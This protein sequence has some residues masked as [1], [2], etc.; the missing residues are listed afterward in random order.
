MYNAFRK[1]TTTNSPVHGM[2]VVFLVLIFF[3]LYVTC[4]PILLW[5][6]SIQMRARTQSNLFICAHTLHSFLHG[7]GTFAVQFKLICM[8]AGA[9]FLHSC[10]WIVAP[11]NIASYCCWSLNLSNFVTVVTGR[12]WWPKIATRQSPGLFSHFA[13]GPGL[14]LVDLSAPEVYWFPKIRFYP[15]S[16]CQGTFGHYSPFDLFTLSYCTMYII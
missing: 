4:K 16:T 7:H 1:I 14:N 2:A 3:V 6:F 10:V 5:K 8:L 11:V 15:S 13:L 12:L 9:T